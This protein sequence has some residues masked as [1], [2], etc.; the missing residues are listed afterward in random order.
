MKFLLFILLC[1]ALHGNTPDKYAW[2]S[3]AAQYMPL[4]V[5]NIW[6]YYFSYTTSGGGANGYEK[7]KITG[8][9]VVNGKT[10]YSFSMERR[11]NFGSNFCFSR[12]FQ[13]PYQLRI[14]S[15]TGNLFK[16]TNCGTN[17]EGMVDSLN[18]RMNDSAF[19]CGNFQENISRCSD[20]SF[21]TILGQ[22]RKTKTF[23]V[24]ANERS[25]THEY[26]QG[27]GLSYF[28][29]SQLMTQCRL[30]LVGCYVNGLF[31]GDTTLFVGISQIGTEIPE[32]YSL[33]QNYPNPFNPVTKI[34]FNIPQNE[35]THRVV[36]TSLIVYDALGRVIAVLVNQQLQPGTYEADWDASAFPSG[37]Y[38][39]KLESGDF[40]ETKKMVLIK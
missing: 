15:S 40:T 33:S 24:H 32:D 31:L 1:I 10:F 3:T 21:K 25:N 35:T 38:Y 5:G 36:S 6:V 27:I 4:Q 28:L 8:T 7:Y 34:K 29:S 23:E 13:T 2:D 11:F 12:L 14:D 22:Y 16:T 39:Y 9:T 17:L 20:T 26:T 19:I 30:Y 37:V 18:S